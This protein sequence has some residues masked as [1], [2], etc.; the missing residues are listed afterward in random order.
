MKRKQKL[1]HPRLL[2]PHSNSDLTLVDSNV[3]RK[4]GMRDRD[5]PDFFARKQALL[6]VKTGNS[7]LQEWRKSYI[8][9]LRVLFLTRGPILRDFGCL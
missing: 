3:N 1:T 5:I 8:I 7:R 9:T 6:C 2:T 4:S